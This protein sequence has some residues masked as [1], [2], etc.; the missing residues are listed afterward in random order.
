VTVAKNTHISGQDM[1]DLLTIDQINRAFIAGTRWRNLEFEQVNQLLIEANSA[2]NRL[3]GAILYARG[4]AI[5]NAIRDI[6]PHIVDLIDR[7]DTLNRTYATTVIE[8][9]PIVDFRDYITS[10]QA[11][12]ITIDEI[13]I[14]ITDRH[15]ELKQN[16]VDLQNIDVPGWDGAVSIEMTRLADELKAKG[17]TWKQVTNRLMSDLQQKKNAN[18][19]DDI[20]AAILDRLEVSDNPQKTLRNRWSENRSRIKSARL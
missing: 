10:F 2:V 15:E 20:E 11:G 18:E 5:K 1:L 14:K 16:F 8:P 17:L 7:I 4:E 19:I 3:E 9:G 12:E 13:R 6:K